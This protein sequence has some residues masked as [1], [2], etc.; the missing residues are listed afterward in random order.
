MPQDVEVILLRPS[1]SGD[2]PRLHR[3]FE[4]DFK[5]RRGH[6]ARWLQFLRLNHPGYRGIDI[7]EANL[8]QLPADGDVRDAVLGV[9][10]E[11]DLPVPRLDS[12]AD[13]DLDLPSGPPETVV[14]PDLLAGEEELEAVR[15]RLG[16]SV[17]QLS[18]L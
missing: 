13:E 6:I 9:E 18:M 5:V 11:A 10:G 1:N 15:Q 12:D 3:Q 14:V 16:P 7:D 17:N 4:R 8:S 2:N